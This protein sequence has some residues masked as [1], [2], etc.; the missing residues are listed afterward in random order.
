[1]A[2][3]RERVMAVIAGVLH[4]ALDHSGA[5]GIRLDGTSPQSDF[6]RE[7]CRRAGAEAPGTDALLAHAANKTALLLSR[8]RPR[9]DLLPL[10]DL[11]AGQVAELAGG[12]DLPAD[13]AAL[14][15]A[16]GGLERAEHALQR[17]LEQ[18]QPPEIALAELPEPVRGPFL[19]AVRGG[20]FW[21]EHC[22]L[23][24]KLSARTI[25]IDLFA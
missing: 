12:Y 10:G 23:V 8:D 14:V 11:Y 2:D 7:C 19:E 4:Q 13:A 5:T 16:A 1:M 17:W 6:C 25:G 22:G 20:R 3:R 15:E 9:A 18:R 21:R 24:P